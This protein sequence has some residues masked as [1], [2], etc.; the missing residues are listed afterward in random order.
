MLAVFLDLEQTNVRVPGIEAFLLGDFDAI[1]TL[2]DREQAVQHRVDREVSAQNFLRNAVTLL[3]QLLAVETAVPALQIRAALFGGI[4][5]ELLEVLSGERFA[6]LGQITQEA[7]HLIAGLGHLGRQAQ[8]GKVRIAQQLRQLLTQIE[9]LLHDRRIVVLASVGAL[10]RSTGVVRRIDF[11]T[12]G[13]VF[14]VGHHRVIARE[15]QGNQIT[16]EVFGFGGGSH[17]L[18]GRARQ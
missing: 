5:L 15:F 3:T 6:A 18:L 4:R 9:N 17:L 7:Q 8:L 2:D 12:Q 10:V 1:Q 11:F 14:G 13:A 16:F